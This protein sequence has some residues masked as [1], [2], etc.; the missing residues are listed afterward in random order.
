MKIISENHFKQVGSSPHFVLR[1]AKRLHDIPI[2]SAIISV[3]LY[4]LYIFYLRN[5]VA[6]VCGCGDKL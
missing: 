3:F 5:I 2:A 1:P 4:L 6:G